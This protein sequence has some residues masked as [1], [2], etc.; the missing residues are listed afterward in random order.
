MHTQEYLW[1]TNPEGRTA[2]NNLSKRQATKKFTI[3]KFFTELE[4]KHWI[5]KL[6]GFHGLSYNYVGGA[7]YTTLERKELRTDF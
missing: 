3:I 4:G 2:T 7:K 1:S 5:R 6:L